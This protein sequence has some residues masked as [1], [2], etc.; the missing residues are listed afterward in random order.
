[1]VHAASGLATMRFSRWPIAWTTGGCPG[2]TVTTLVP[3]A[4]TRS[5]AIARSTGSTAPARTRRSAAATFAGSR[6]PSSPGPGR[7]LGGEAERGGGHRAGLPPQAVI[8]HR[9]RRR[10]HGLD[11]VEPAHRRSGRGRAAPLGPLPRVAERER[12][13]PQE[14]VAERDDHARPPE[15]VLRL[16][17]RAERDPA[18]LGGALAARRVKGEARPGEAH[19]KAAHEIADQRRAGRGEEEAEP[20]AAVGAAGAEAGAER[21]P[22]G[23]PLGRA[24]GSG[25]VGIVEAEDGRLVVGRRGA[26]ARGVIRVALDLG[27]APVVALA[28]PAGGEPV[29]REARRVA[30]GHAGGG[31]PGAPR[32]GQDLLSTHPAAAAE[33]RQR[34]AGAEELER[35]AAVHLAARGELGE[36]LKGL[37]PGLTTLDDRELPVFAVTHARPLAVARRAVGQAADPQLRHQLPAELGLPAAR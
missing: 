20:R 32:I 25:P 12:P 37:P 33:P 16:H 10:E 21:L 13:R 14:I 35:L 19:A 26:E 7:H 5:P 27:G 11:H 23:R 6:R 30:A 9:A 22:G 15:I 3:A 29:E 8:G 34:H 31:V 24:E 4:R 18:A 1:M 17:G 2:P 28:E 36:A